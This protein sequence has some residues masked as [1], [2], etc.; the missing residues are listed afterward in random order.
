MDLGSTDKII[1]EETTKRLKLIKV[2]HANPYKV[3]WLNQE[4]SVLVN[5]QT[6]VEFSIGSYKEKVLCDV[7]PMDACHLILE[8]PWKF[9]RK[10][11]YNGEENAISFKKD[12]RTF[13][14]QSLIENE[15]DTSKTPS[16]LFSSGKEFLQAL[17]DEQTIGCAIMV[18]PKEEEKLQAILLEVQQILDDF[19][20]II[21]DGTPTILPPKREI[22]HQ[23]DFVP[24]ASLPNKE[25][26]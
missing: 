3:T 6:W 17:Q 11:I 22:S 2:P 14:I 16:V 24:G 20:D 12:G 10:V 13:K 18:N 21:S 15:G 1:S 8:R 26:Y 25:A 19:K 5:E 7:L 9:D 4:K 23:I